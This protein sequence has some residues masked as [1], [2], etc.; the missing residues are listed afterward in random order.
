MNERGQGRKLDANRNEKSGNKFSVLIDSI[1]SC[2]VLFF[3]RMKILSSISILIA[4]SFSAYHNQ[5]C[6]LFVFFIFLF[7]INLNFFFLL[8]LHLIFFFLIC[9]CV[10]VH[11]LRVTIALKRVREQEYQILNK[12]FA[13][14]VTF[15]IFTLC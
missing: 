14:L 9:V 11:C 3:F 10:C 5:M 4:L 13:I 12:V 1:N 15:R 6:D 8:L 2:S 7:R